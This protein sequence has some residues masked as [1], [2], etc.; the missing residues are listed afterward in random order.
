M[1]PPFVA[2]MVTL[3]Q[4]RHD[5]SHANSGLIR[6]HVFVG[7]AGV[8]TSTLIL[9]TAALIGAGLP[10]VAFTIDP[11]GPIGGRRAFKVRD[12]VLGLHSLG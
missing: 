10:K 7:F 5:R 6:F 11:L 8:L 9:F 1:L 12:T 4:R 2:A 3:A